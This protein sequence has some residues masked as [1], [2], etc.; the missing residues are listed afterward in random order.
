MSN[1]KTILIIEDEAL[2]LR[3][4]SEGFTRR[5]YKV[6]KADDGEVGIA[7]L[8]KETPDV[9]L[10]DLILPKVSGQ[11]VLKFM[12][13]KK[14]I[15]KIPVVVLTNV[16]DGSSLKECMELGAK[17]YIIKANFSF[18][19]MEDTIKRAMGDNKH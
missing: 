15:K 14:I 11:E 8:E 4:L 3:A 9:I 16:S 17:E 19:D 18:D 6:L 13:E 10:L 1:K 7:A 12:N 2:I 5:G